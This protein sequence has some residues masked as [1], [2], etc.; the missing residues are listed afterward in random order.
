MSEVYILLLVKW[1]KQV[2][3]KF[4]RSEFDLNHLFSCLKT[5]LR[6]LCI[7]FLLGLVSKILL[8]SAKN[9]GRALCATPSGK[10]LMYTTNSNGPKIDPCGTPRVTLVHFE[11]VCELQ[12]E[13]VIWSLWYLLQLC[14]SVLE[15]WP[16]QRRGIILMMMMCCHHLKVHFRT[17]NCNAW[18]YSE[19]VILKYPVRDKIYKSSLLER[20]SVKIIVGDEKWSR[21]F[22]LI[23]SGYSNSAMLMYVVGSKSFW[24]DQ[25]FKETE[26]KQL[27][28]F[29]T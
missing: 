16:L 12:Y 14:H 23:F 9:I 11:T 17:L 1:I 3:S 2:L 18:L 22:H 25:L 7:W 6:S 29:S 21:F 24:P 5:I 20:W 13:F 28:Y 8:S 19:N 27:C 15:I 26:I 4:N 10:S